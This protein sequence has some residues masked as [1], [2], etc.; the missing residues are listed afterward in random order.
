MCLEIM[1]GRMTI[2]EGR[3]ALKE[4]VNTTEDAKQLEHYRELS[5]ASDEE[6]K[7]IIEETKE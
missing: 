3:H 2:K 4:L 7:K 1:K 6:I 5:R